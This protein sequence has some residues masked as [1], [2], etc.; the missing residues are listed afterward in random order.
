M[1]GRI[2]RVLWGAGRGKKA[3]GPTTGLVVR[4]RQ[5]SFF[6]PLGG[7]VCLLALRF[8][9]RLASRRLR[10][11]WSKESR[12]P[13]GLIGVDWSIDRPVV[14]FPSRRVQN[15]P[16]PS[17]R[18]A[19]FESR[20]PLQVAKECFISGRF[21]FSCSCSTYVSGDFGQKPRCLFFGY[22]GLT[23]LLFFCGVLLYL[24]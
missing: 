16:P 21:F 6:K 13:G 15:P 19:P 2:A 7:L 23:R 11:R 5:G 9:G 17:S 4:G 12:R 3:T 22:L 10:R 14:L 1:V 20:S 24:T 18:E 8:A